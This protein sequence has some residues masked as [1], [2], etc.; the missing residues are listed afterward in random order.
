MMVKEGYLEG[1]EYLTK[2]YS[3]SRVSEVV[4]I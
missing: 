1:V 4:V 3:S 2:K